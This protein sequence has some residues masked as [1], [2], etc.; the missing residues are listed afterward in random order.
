MQAR[1][2]ERPRIARGR[3][4]DVHGSPVA[5]RQSRQQGPGRARAKGSIAGLTQQ[6]IG[7]MPDGKLGPPVRGLYHRLYQPMQGAVDVD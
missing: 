1:V 4:R 6:H 7:V 2:S 3:A 5:L